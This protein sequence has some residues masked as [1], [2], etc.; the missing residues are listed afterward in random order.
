[1][2]SFTPP[3]TTRNETRLE[4]LLSVFT[5]VEQEAV[6]TSAA[7]WSISEYGGA[8][9]GNANG[10]YDTFLSELNDLNGGQRG[11]ARDTLI[12]VTALNRNFTLVTNDS[13]LS[14]VF[15]SNGGTIE[16][17]EEFSS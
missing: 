6:P 3:L 9:Y 8:Q 5:S 2:R 11:N 12:A 13:D 10:L 7:V 17:F 15:Q 1:M 4:A 14:T 16:T